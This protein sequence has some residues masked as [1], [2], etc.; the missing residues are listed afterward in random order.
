[1]YPNF[2]YACWKCG[3]QKASFFHMRW[4]CKK[5]KRFWQ[6][7]YMEIKDIMHI[8]LPVAPQVFLLDRIENE[9]CRHLMNNVVTAASILLAKYWKEEPVPSRWEWRIEGNQIWLMSKLFVYKIV[10]VSWLFSSIDT[11]NRYWHCYIKN[12]FSKKNGM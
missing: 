8:I 4:D 7:V 10:T 1:M 6:M 12:V 9:G 11:F 2:C 3:Y 5:V